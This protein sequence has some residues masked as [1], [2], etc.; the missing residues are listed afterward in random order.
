MLLSERPNDHRIT[1]ETATEFLVLPRAAF[2]E[3]L[4]RKETVAQLLLERVAQILVRRV[5]NL[6]QTLTALLSAAQERD[7]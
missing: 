1:A 7:S 2:E 3:L 4:A 6:N 5:R